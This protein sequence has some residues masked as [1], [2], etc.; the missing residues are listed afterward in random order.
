VGKGMSPVHRRAALLGAGLL[1][2]GVPGRRAGAAPPA[3]ARFRILREGTP[4]GAHRV[5]FAEAPDG[6]LSALT[7]VDVA[8]RLAGITVFRLTHR[9]DE[10]WAADRLRIATS[11]L[12]RNGRVTEMT[13]RAEGGAIL[14]RGPEGVL[15]LPPEAAPLT[16]WDARRLEG[17]PLFD[18][19]T[20]KP[21]QL[22]WT[23]A[24]APGGAVR[25][26][27]AGDEE[28]EGIYAADGRWLGWTTRA[29]DGS[30]VTYE[31]V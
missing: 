16:W 7:E 8:V 10:V 29:E 17:R 30:T 4:I 2:S 23:R 27:C 5:T 26:R 11:R 19:D 20:G 9:F 1:L 25:W 12:D 15:R 3:A 22:R 28:A 14:V 6:A 21:L 13:A 31:R 18:N 24:A